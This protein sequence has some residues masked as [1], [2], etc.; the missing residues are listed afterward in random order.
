MYMREAPQI[1]LIKN[2][3]FILMYLNFKHLQNTLHWMQYTYWDIFCTAQNSFWTRQFWRLLEL[4][5][6]FVS[7]L[8][9]QQN[10]SLWGYF[11][12]GETKKMLFGERS[13]EM[14]ERDM[15]VMTCLDKNLLSTQHGIGRFTRKSPIRKWVN[16]L[17]LQKFTESEH[18]LSQQCQLVHWY[19]WIPRTPTKQGKPVLKEAHPPGGNS[20][21]FGVPHHIR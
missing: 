17:S 1:E 6:F 18:S 19:R 11:S 4:L 8:P 14:E 5:P 3:V 13:G 15:G 2:C 12:F 7:P 10:F 9:H 20:W 21:Y 16:V